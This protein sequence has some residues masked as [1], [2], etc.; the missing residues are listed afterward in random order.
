[1]VRLV[2]YNTLR[3]QQIYTDDMFLIYINLL[4]LFTFLCSIWRRS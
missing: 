4:N 2:Q 1:M 3:V